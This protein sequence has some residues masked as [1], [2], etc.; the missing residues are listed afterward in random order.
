MITGKRAAHVE[1][2]LQKMD[3]AGHRAKL[4]SRS[5]F[6]SCC[7]TPLHSLNPAIFKSGFL[8]RSHHSSAVDC[9]S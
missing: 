7:T 8:L 9:G 6:G 1:S 2:C 5:D 3:L 4:R